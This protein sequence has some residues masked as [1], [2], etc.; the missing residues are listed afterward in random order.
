M[1]AQAPT[2]VHKYEA[3]EWA[4]NAARCVVL[5]WKATKMGVRAAPYANTCAHSQES[6]TMRLASATVR[7]LIKIPQRSMYP[8]S[9]A[10]A[11][12]PGGAVSKESWRLTPVAHNKNLGK[13]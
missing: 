10:R 7:H 9:I 6:M 1:T 12:I 5:A 4:G 13:T 3:N 2:A 8:K 11:R